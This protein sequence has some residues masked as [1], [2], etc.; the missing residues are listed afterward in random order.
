MWKHLCVA[1]I[2]GLVWRFTDRLI[3]DSQETTQ[4]II[5]RNDEVDQ[6]NYVPHRS[7]HMGMRDVIQSTVFILQSILT[8]QW[9]RNLFSRQIVTSKNFLELAMQL[10][11]AM[12]ISSVV[13]RILREVSQT[14][15]I[16]SIAKTPSTFGKLAFAYSTLTAQDELD[17]L[18][19]FNTD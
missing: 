3:Q 11:C 10:L 14:P 9:W 6:V 15:H 2:Q 7:W 16:F 12:Q 5:G 8:C 18:S 1:E 17:Q 4:N 19:L 13:T